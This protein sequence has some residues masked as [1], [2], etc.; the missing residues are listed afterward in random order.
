MNLTQLK[1]FRLRVKLSLLFIAFVFAGVSQTNNTCANAT[2]FCT[3]NTMQFPA[4]VN[5][6][7]A[8]SGPNYGCLGSQPNP[9]WFYMQIANGGP[10]TLVMSAPQDIDF[11][12][13]GPFPNL[14]TSCSNLTSGNIVSCSYS[15]ASTETCTIANAIP[16]Q[17]YILLITNFSNAN[18]Q[19]TFN[20]TN[21]N[22]AN[23]GS[24]NCGVIC[25]ITATNSGAVCSGQSATLSLTTN[26]AITSYTWAGPGGFSSNSSSP[27]VNNITATSVYTLIGSTSTSTCQAT[28][29]VNVVTPPNYTVTPL[30]TTVCQGG[31]FTPSVT[32]GQSFQGT[33]CSNTGVGPACATPN[34]SQIG[35]QTGQNGTTTW[36]A[37]YGNWYRNARHQMLFTAAELNAAGI[38][39]GYLTSLAF[40]VITING[41]TTYPG[42]TIRIK[43][44]NVTALSGGFDN[45]GFSQVFSAN[46]IVTV[47]WNTHNFT[48]PYYWDGVSNL[49]VDVCYS[50]TGNYTQNCISPFMTT[51]FNSCRVWYS[52]VTQACM[53]T[54]NPL[55]TNA[56]RPLVRWGSCTTPNPNAFSY[57]WSPQPGIAAPT[58]SSTPITT[59]PI[60][61]TNANIVYSV[62]VTP[63]NMN[64]PTLQTL[65]VTVLNP[66]TPTLT[67][68]GPICNTGAQVML[69]ATPGGGT[70]T[71]NNAISA[72]GLLT[73]SLATIG[74]STVLYS[75][76]VGS[77][78]ATNTA[79][80]NVSQFNS[81]ALTGTVPPLCVTSAPVNL[82]T[83]VQSTVN[84][85]WSG[86]GVTNNT[87]TP[88]QA[89]SGQFMLSYN[90]TSSPNPTVCPDVS[91]LQVSVTAT[92]TPTITPV[93]SMCNTFPSITM[94][95][96]PTGG[97][98]FGNTGVSPTGVFTP[99]LAP[100]GTSVVNYSVNVGPCVVNS[101]LNVSVSQFNTAAFSGSI[102]PLCV[103]NPVVN[104]NGIVQSTVNGIWA[105][106]NVAGSSFS[107]AGLPTGVYTLSYNTTSSPDPTVCPD[108]N[109]IQVSVLNPPTPVITP[110]GPFCNNTF[111]QQ[112][113]VSPNTGTWTTVSYQN[114]QGVFIPSLAAIG[115]NTVQYVI[116]TNTCNTQATATIQVESFVPATITGT[117]ADQ[118]NTNGQVNLT[119]LTAAN[120]GT[121]SGSGVTGVAFNPGTSGTGSIILTYNT[122]SVPSGLCPDQSTL[123]VNVFS[124]ASPSLGSI[125]PF[126]NS[127]LPMQIPVTPLGGIFSGVNNNAV[128]GT[129][130]FNPS[131]ATIGNNLINYSVSAG[132]CIAFAQTTISVEKFISADLSNYAGPFCRNEGPINL[133]SLVQNQGGTWSGGAGL[134]GN[135][136]SP[137]FANPGNDNVFV[138]STHSSPT[139]SLCPDSSSIRIQ[140]NDIPVINV[141]SNQDRGCL[142]VEV[143]FNTPSVNSGQGVWHLGDGTVINGLTVTHIYN[144]P[145]SY[146]VTFNYQ[147]E[148]GCSAIATLPTP[149]NVYS[150][151]NAA[152]NYSPDQITM[153]KPEVNFSNQSTVLGSNTYQWQ[154][155]N[156]YQLNDVNP[157]VVF[158]GP[159]DYLIT[160]TATSV[161]GCKD[162]V[163]KMIT[164]LNDYGVYIPSSFTPN[165]DGLNDY[166]LPVFSPYGLDLSVYELE[167]FDRWGHSLFHTKD[168][169]QG[170]DGMAKGS[171]EPLK[172]DVYVYKIKFKD[173]DG[174]IHHKT[175]HVSILK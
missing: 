48:T 105:G 15:G 108:A 175:G 100:N 29:S 140:V 25:S 7:S 51:G 65:T 47:G 30:T 52:D 35:T 54:N 71:T 37:P 57:L 87:F 127:H 172:Q 73:P 112:I 20:Q 149:I 114:L 78:I 28:T 69:T 62:V 14:S 58:A 21:S 129:G 93:N 53:T 83:L 135:M 171:D 38:G 143:I 126:C 68:P 42:Y 74:T 130:I 76:V 136:F 26:T 170:W 102:S 88:A 39:M 99:S 104:L 164:V 1:L 165:F 109:S 3:G 142:P 131:N 79:A 168:V 75:T 174:K 145:G 18:Q 67:V 121:W 125:G 91:T 45:A 147:D 119:P 123:A 96:N 155:G 43:C 64:C 33:P 152:F 41:T 12:C 118:C 151:P 167:I 17:F 31:I 90:T 11:I 150:V 128:T 22:N 157:Y 161:N 115:N 124:L 132:P 56:S 146:T 4:G 60:S 153:I 46:H 113:I 139:A 27:V 77:C 89:G 55:I 163:T 24:T 84:G 40:N 61:G 81:A 162:A 158:P 49:L 106:T 16:G 13:W 10:I 103:T 156:L 85:V 86:S 98:W 66:L 116:G 169:N 32:F 5:A 144:T 9:A 148:I 63:T 160:L 117:I 122:Q 134:S 111:P 138:Y 95:V 173:A 80:I 23:A 107:P 92:L 6:G 141:V 166:F 44:T 72:G 34:I 97:A 133:N 110:A 94:T 2:P 137:A 70:W 8:Q 50:M 36:P 19:I 159:G 154:I 59:Q 120:S 101:S 82:M